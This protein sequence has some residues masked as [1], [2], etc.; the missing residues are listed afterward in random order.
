[1]SK[2]QVIFMSLVAALPAA[3]LVAA[4]VLNGMEHGGQMFSGLMTVVVALTGLLC[5]FGL[6]GLPFY[7]MAFYPAEG[8]GAMIPQPPPADQTPAAKPSSA[9]DDEFEDDDDDEELGGFDADDDEFEDDDFGSD[10]SF[11]DDDFE[12]DEDF[13]ADDWE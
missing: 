1:M 6:V 13:D 7:V 12:D 8:F 11:G 9:D 5:L 2:K 4:L 10:D 3:G